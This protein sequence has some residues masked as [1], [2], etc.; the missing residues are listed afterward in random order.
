Y[1]ATH[2]RTVHEVFRLDAVDAFRRNLV[3]RIEVAAAT[4]QAAH[5]QPYVKLI[6]VQTRKGSGPRATL[7]LDVRGA[8]DAVL[9]KEVTLHGNED[10]EQETKRDIYR[11]VRLG[12]IRGGK[13]DDQM[14]E[15]RL[16]G[17]TKWLR[18]NE[19]H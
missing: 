5:N 3:K 11:D 1:S 18:R 6:K 10:L 14:I 12:E 19:V 7:E 2:L 17:E 9:R 4:A 13:A 16:P 15:L 8:K